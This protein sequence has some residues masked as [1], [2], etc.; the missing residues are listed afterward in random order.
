M[1]RGVLTYM[2][3]ILG[4]LSVSCDNDDGKKFLREIYFASHGNT[5]AVGDTMELRVVYYPKASNAGIPDEEM[6]WST[7]D[8]GAVR[9]DVT[10]DRA[11]RITAINIGSATVTAT[12]GGFNVSTKIVIDDYDNP[13]EDQAFMNFC[14][15]NFDTNGDGKLQGSEVAD[16]ESMDASDILNLKQSHY[17]GSEG[18]DTI[19][20]TMTTN[21]PVSFAGI[22][23]FRSL[24]SFKANRVIIGHLDLSKNT[25][26]VSVDV[27]ESYI[28][29][30]DVSRNEKLRILDCHADTA[31]GDNLKLGSMEEF[32]AN[33]IFTIICNRSL[34]TSLD[35]SRCTKLNYIDCSQ[36][37]LTELDLTN[38]LE[39]TQITCYDNN[40]TEVRV[41]EEYD[42]EQ[43]KSFIADDGV[44]LTH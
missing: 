14:L 24:K 4:L 5:L 40:L 25:N 22:E 42:Q 9:I 7:N 20:Y 29:S 34:I 16:V 18:G 38:S 26:L 1:R 8:S 19:T 27:S 28:E 15:E 3:I 12:L 41:S 36:N 10:G 17:I 13:I 33:N 6:T 35:L 32:G 21:E 2:T 31:L 37:M 39:L 23:I 43:L 11:A 44:S 30:L